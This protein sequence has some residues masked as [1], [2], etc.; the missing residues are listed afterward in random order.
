MS[1]PTCIRL[2]TRTRSRSDAIKGLMSVADFYG[3]T[4]F[5]PPDSNAAGQEKLYTPTTALDWEGDD[6]VCS[7]AL[8][9]L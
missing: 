4:D 5:I 2:R 8:Y 6:S 1:R 3:T 9:V 7:T